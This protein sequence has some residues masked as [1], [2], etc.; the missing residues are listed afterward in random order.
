MKTASTDNTDRGP[1]L[2]EDAE[3][4]KSKWTDELEEIQCH[5]ETLSIAST[6]GSLR[7]EEFRALGFK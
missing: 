6:E 5:L 3:F 4:E 2:G 7:L 1:L